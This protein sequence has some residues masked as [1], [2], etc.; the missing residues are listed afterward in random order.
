MVVLSTR[1]NI[2]QT[3]CLDF[4][5]TFGNITNFYFLNFAL[6][7]TVIRVDVS[8]IAEYDLPFVHLRCFHLFIDV[9]VTI[10]L[11]PFSRFGY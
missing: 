11:G 6:N 8:S 2:A 10:S 1:T 5:N 9:T 3:T 4:C 7:A